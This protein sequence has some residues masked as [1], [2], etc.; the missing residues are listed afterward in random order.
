[1]KL[2]LTKTPKTGFVA[3]RPNYALDLVTY[4]LGTAQNDRHTRAY[5]CYKKKKRK[6]KRSR[7]ILTGS[8]RMQYM[9]PLPVKENLPTQP[10]HGIDTIET[11]CTRRA[12][13]SRGGYSRRWHK[14]VYLA[15]K[16]GNTLVNNLLL[17]IF[18]ANYC[19]L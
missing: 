2:A 13:S 19:H 12:Q 3:T 16:K 1:M 18:I 11:H 7:T 4:C 5:T 17:K 6:R 8:F 10:T 14:I 15:V 9:S